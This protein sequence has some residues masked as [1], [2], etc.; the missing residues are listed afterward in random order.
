M[1]TTQGR[2]AQAHYGV[3]APYVPAG[4]LLGAVVAGVLAVLV[5]LGQ[6]AANAIGLWV[7]AALALVGAV[8]YLHTT[9]R[10]KFA[11]WSRVLD[12]LGLQGS[13]DA[14][15]MGCGRGAVLLA[16][17]RRLPTGHVTGLDLWRSRDQSGNEIDTTRANAV[18]EGV[19]DRVELVTGDMTSMPFPDGRFDLVVSSLAIHNIHGGEGR[20]AAIDEALRVLRPG[21][22]LVIADIQATRLYARRL[23]ERGVDHVRRRRLG[24]Q[25]WWSGPWMA[26][27]LVRGRPPRG[28][29]SAQGRPA[30][31]GFVARRIWSLRNDASDSPAACEMGSRKRTGEPVVPV[32]HRAGPGRATS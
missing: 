17:A 16:L 26:T 4:F 10:G 18:A 23:R 13:E 19:V 20:M 30:G 31:R 8:T 5:T 9:W 29:L 24:P 2:P 22:R 7:V 12:D 14:L 21:G 11:V 25:A 1:A 6:G 3:D 27:S 15:D 28:P 32:A